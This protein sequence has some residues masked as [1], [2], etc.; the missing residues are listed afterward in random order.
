MN[1]ASANTF[2]IPANSSVAYPIGTQLT[3]MQIGAG[4]TTVAINTDT[5]NVAATFT[6]NIAEQYS[7]VTVIKITATQ[8]VLIGDLEAV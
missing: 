4:Q 8:W 5:L 7:I 1:N 6:T 2:T 3:I